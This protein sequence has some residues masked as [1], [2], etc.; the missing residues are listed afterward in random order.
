MNIQEPN[1]PGSFSVNQ[2]SLMY[3]CIV[4]LKPKSC[5]EIGSF[6][7]R[8]A[9]LISIALKDLGG[10]RSLTCLDSFERP[11]T[12]EYFEKRFI[13]HPSA[14]QMYLDRVLKR[15]GASNYQDIDFCKYAG[16]KELFLIT[17]DIYPFMKDYINLIHSDSRKIDLTDYEFDF[18]FLDGDHTKKGVLNDVRKIIPALNKEISMVAFHDYSEQ[19]K[20]VKKVADKFA[21][22]EGVTLA[23]SVENL[24]IFN[25][26]SISSLASCFLSEE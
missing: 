21:E 8:S 18:V 22:V 26:K 15:S 3:D 9:W 23:G 5:L 10:Q 1:I 4:Q 6:M 7:G 20:G 12:Q 13:Y 25:V 24:I 16:L 2:M 11:A 19:Y 17:Q 14:R